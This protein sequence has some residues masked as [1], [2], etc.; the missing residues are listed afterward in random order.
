MQSVINWEELG[1][2]ANQDRRHEARVA[3]AIPIEVT[4]FDVDGTFFSEITKTTDISESGCGFSL[5]RCV[6]RGGIVAIKVAMKD[7]KQKIRRPFL[8]QVARAIPDGSRWL[9]GAAKLQPESIWLL[10]FPKTV[11]TAP[12]AD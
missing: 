6:E 5:K 4:G 12:A 11:S 9:L 7:R 3:L 8:Y 10:T 2:A 1:I